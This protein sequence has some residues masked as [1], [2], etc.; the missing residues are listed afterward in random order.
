MHANLLSSQERKGRFIGKQGANMVQQTVSELILG[1]RHLEQSR[2]CE[3]GV[4]NLVNALHQALAVRTVLQHRHTQLEV[5]AS[6]L[7]ELAKALHLQSSSSA[8]HISSRV[9]MRKVV[10]V[11]GVLS[12]PL[13]CASQVSFLLQLIG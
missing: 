6:T 3:G 2:G 12:S 5:L 1:N 7:E 11:A 8:L 13:D 9:C 10:Q 4:E